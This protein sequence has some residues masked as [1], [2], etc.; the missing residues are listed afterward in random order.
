MDGTVTVTVSSQTSPGPKL[1]PIR[2]RNEPPVTVPPPQTEPEGT[3]VAVSPERTASRL[4][5]KEMFDAPE[6]VS[7]FSILKRR[8]LVPVATAGPSKAL[9]KLRTCTFRSSLAAAPVTLR[10]PTLPVTPVVVLGKTLPP[11]AP[12]GRTSVSRILQ[13]A[14]AARVPPE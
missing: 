3:V 6:L 1:A 7:R 8:S 12:E 14:A 10:E 9:V 13:V 5:E 11:S 4:S 2:V